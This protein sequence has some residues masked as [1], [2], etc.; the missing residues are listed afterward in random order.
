LA[1]LNITGTNQYVLQEMHDTLAVFP[2]IVVTT[3]LLWFCA[4]YVTYE[5]YDDAL[6]DL[7]D[8]NEIV[9]TG[10]NIRRTT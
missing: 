4:Q 3:D 9:R 1:S 6:K 5:M 7:Q 2:Y 10:N 8:D